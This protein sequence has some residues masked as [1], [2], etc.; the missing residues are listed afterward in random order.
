MAKDCESCGK[1]LTRRDNEKA[2]LFAKRR[3]CDNSCS[4]R[5]KG[6]AVER[7]WSF[8]QKTESCWLWIGG[9]DHGGYGMLKVG[10]RA[11]RRVL[12]HR[13]SYLVAHGVTPPNV[14]HHCDVPACVRPEHLFAGTIADNV[15][16]MISKG[17]AAW[18]KRA[19]ASQ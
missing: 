2:A 12:A 8:V 4:K 13:F 15:A 18:Q 1:E 17:R 11:G 3:F 9:V 6:S 19:A 14:L 5:T 10:G 7:F 16:D